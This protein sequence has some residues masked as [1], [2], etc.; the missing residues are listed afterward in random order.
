V[1][2]IALAQLPTPLVEAPRLSE[3]LGVHVLVKRDDLTGLALGG[4]KARKLEHLLADARARGCDTLVAAG[5]AQSN[6]AR[7]TAAAAA[8]LGLRCHLV[9]SGREPERFSGNLVLDRL[10]GAT[11]HF[12]GSGDWRVLED[13]VAKLAQELGPGAYPMPIG[14]ATA[15]GALGYVEASDE[16]LSQLAAPPDWLVL[17]DGSGGTHAGLLAGLPARVRILGVDVAR[18]P[19]PHAERIPLL[20]AETARLAGRTLPGGELHLVDHTGSRYGAVTEECIDAVRLVARSEG[21]LLDPVYS[22]KAMAGLRLAVREGRISGTVVF[23][24]TGGAPA[25][26]ADDYVGVMG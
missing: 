10:F 17:A 3:A 1:D 22:G 5:G 26:F 12:A 13:R 7:M 15:V 25:L 9:L 23:L 18:P 6:F 24:H 19:T 16:L 14:G 8:Q 2:R 20:A 21:M 4:N 11:L